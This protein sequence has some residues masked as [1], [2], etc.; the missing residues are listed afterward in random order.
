[1]AKDKTT[2]PSSATRNFGGLRWVYSVAEQNITS[3]LSLLGY[4]FKFFYDLQSI[5]TTSPSI[6]DF[7]WV[8]ENNNTKIANW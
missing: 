1:M 4:C 3:L 7:K 2:P 8:R 5:Q 6:E